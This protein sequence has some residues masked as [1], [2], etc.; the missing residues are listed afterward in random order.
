[1]PFEYKA[2]IFWGI[3]QGVQELDIFQNA[4]SRIVKKEDSKNT[5]GIR[6]ASGYSKSRY[7]KESSNKD[8]DS[9]D[10]NASIIA[11]HI[12]KGSFAATT[13]LFSGLLDYFNYEDSSED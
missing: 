12:F 9:F 4:S 1:M 10:W 13:D 11:E 8:E 5:E 2:P 3:N 7:V 6:I